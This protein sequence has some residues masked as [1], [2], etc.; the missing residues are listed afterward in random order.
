MQPQRGWN[1]RQSITST[2]FKTMW[3]LSIKIHSRPL[4]T[5][6]YQNYVHSS[7]RRFWGRTP[8]QK[9]SKH[10]MQVLKDK[11]Q[12]EAC[13]EGIKIYGINLKWD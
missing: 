11:H 13:S 12:V 9:K 6:R 2:A 8:Q 5:R 10:I 3:L 4:E 7:G 1:S